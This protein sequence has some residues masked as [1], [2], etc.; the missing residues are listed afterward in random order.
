M[1]LRQYFFI[2][3]TALL[4]L[5]GCTTT[6]YVTV[7][8][9]HTDTVRITKVQRDSIFLHD[10]IHVVERQQG[11]TLLVEVERWHTRYQEVLRID[12]AYIARRDSV[13]VPYPVVQ[14]VPAELNWWQQAR[15]HLANIVLYALAVLAGWWL[16]KKRAWWLAFFGRRSY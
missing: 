13:G 7:P 10:S 2:I 12:T 16:L 15:L 1:E 11:D 9:V 3:L 5:C 8:E 4:V 14:K 6:R